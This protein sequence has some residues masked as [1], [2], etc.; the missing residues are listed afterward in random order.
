MKQV[1]GSR[2]GQL[3][4]LFNKT[5]TARFM[6]EASN[7]C[8]SVIVRGLFFLATGPLFDLNFFQLHERI[9]AW[10]RQRRGHLSRLVGGNGGAGSSDGATRLLR[11][12]MD[13]ARGRKAGSGGWR[14][15]VQDVAR[16]FQLRS[17]ADWKVDATS[18]WAQLRGLR[19]QGAFAWLGESRHRVRWR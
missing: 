12:R 5:Q 13:R 10:G 17:G 11:W 19:C 7:R 14:C 4:N 8:T 1:V 3:N 18:G 15:Q 9:S 6:P 2:C 16:V